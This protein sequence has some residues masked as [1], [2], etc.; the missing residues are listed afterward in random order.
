[1]LLSFRL[2]L[3]ISL[4][5]TGSKRPRQFLCNYKKNMFLTIRQVS[6]PALGFPVRLFVRRVVK[7]AFVN[8][9]HTRNPDPS[10]KAPSF[11][12]LTC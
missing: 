4:D 7:L 5:A 6:L 1:M 8:K 3:F 10:D 9:D 12:L 11:T 2:V